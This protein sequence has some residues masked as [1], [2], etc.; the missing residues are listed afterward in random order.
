LHI[1]S[2]SPVCSH[3]LSDATPSP[4]GQ[5]QWTKTHPL[6]LCPCSRIIPMLYPLPLGL[7]C[8]KSPTCIL[9]PSHWVVSSVSFRCCT[10]QGWV[11]H[12]HECYQSL[13][14][15]SLSSYHLGIPSCILPDFLLPLLSPFLLVT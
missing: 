5:N 3:A 13:F 7:I 15:P 11:R 4:L 9:P 1:T 6:S 8:T 2:R 12:R 14:Q 10:G